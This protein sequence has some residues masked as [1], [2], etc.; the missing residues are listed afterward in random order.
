[1][2][3]N[4]AFVAL[5]YA[6]K[7]AL[8]C[9]STNS[10][11]HISCYTSSCIFVE[12]QERISFLPVLLYL[13]VLWDSVPILFFLLIFWL[14]FFVFRVLILFD[15]WRQSSLIFLVFFVLGFLLLTFFWHLNKFGHWHRFSFHF[16]ILPQKLRIFHKT[17]KLNMN[18]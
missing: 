2:F 4:P 11:K 1:M 14:L 7:S 15:V 9:C 10:T 3:L 12:S 16:F 8:S 6:R 5:V 17:F 18:N 13:Q